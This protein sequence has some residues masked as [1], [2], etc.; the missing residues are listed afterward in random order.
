MKIKNKLYV[1]A[2]ISIVLVVIL[3]SLVVVT[4]GRIA[5]GNRKH[6]L[7]DSVRGGIVELD[8]VTYDYLLHREERMEQQWSS[9]YGS[10]R[11]ILEKSVEEEELISISTD[12]TAL[13]DLFSQVTANSEEIQKLTQEGASQE[14]ID[15]ATGLEERL[16]AQ[17]LIASH[18]VITDASGLAE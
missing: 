4:S 13:G 18:S 10:L 14:E 2:G 16:V 12:Y 7:L 8:L 3:L 5:E 9:R 15:A 6:E 11:E 1:S 17:L